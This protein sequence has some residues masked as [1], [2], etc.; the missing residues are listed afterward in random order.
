MFN[1]SLRRLLL[2]A[3]C[4]ASLT[5]CN[6]STE[7]TELKALEARLAATQ[8]EVAELETEVATLQSLQAGIV[9]GKGEDALLT[10]SGDFSALL[11]VGETD[12]FYPIPYAS[13]P[14]LIL[15]VELNH[16]GAKLLAQ[17][18]NGYRLSLTRFPDPGIRSLKWQARGI[19]ASSCQ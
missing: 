3:F 10:Q 8:A 9:C 1:P 15:P 7:N 12:I 17:R 13:P 5:S 18:A 4:L 6:P 11:G 2:A 19:A 16:I 14:E